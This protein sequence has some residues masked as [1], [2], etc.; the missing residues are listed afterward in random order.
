[1]SMF[2]PFVYWITSTDH[3]NP[4]RIMLAS[5]KV[6]E[7]TPFSDNMTTCSDSSA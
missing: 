1:M 6:F 3:Q 5:I 7:T 2:D 4:S